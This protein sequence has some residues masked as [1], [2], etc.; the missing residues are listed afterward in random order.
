VIIEK[1]SLKQE[2]DKNKRQFNNKNLSKR[3]MNNM[4]RK[5]PLSMGRLITIILL[6]SL[7]EALEYLRLGDNDSNAEI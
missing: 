2:K 1:V 5:W 4:L 3:D 7:K 6:T